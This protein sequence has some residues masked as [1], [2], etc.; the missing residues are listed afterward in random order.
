M[1]KKSL[2]KE[3]FLIRSNRIHGNRYDYSSV[4]FQ[5]TKTKVDIICYKHGIFSQQPA[6]HMNGQGCPFCYKDFIETRR[7]IKKTKKKQRVKVNPFEGKSL[8]EMKVIQDKKIKTN[9]KRYGVEN[10]SQIQSVKELK[11]RKLLTHEEICKEFNLLIKRYPKRYSHIISS[12]PS[13]IKILNEYPQTWSIAEKVYAFMYNDSKICLNGN[14]RRFIS[15]NKGFGYCG[16]GNNCKCYMN[17]I[18]KITSEGLKNRT[19][20]DRN[21]TLNKRISTTKE[22]YGV[23]N[24]SQN[25][26]IKEKKKTTSLKNNG[27]ISVLQS[28]T[29]KKGGMIRK[30]GVDNPMHLESV[31]EKVRKTNLKRYGTEVASKSDIIKNKTRQTMLERYGSQSYSQIHIPKQSMEILLDRNKLRNFISNRSVIEAASELG[32][33]QPCLSQYLIRNELNEPGRSSYERELLTMFQNWGL[34]VKKND[35]TEIYPNEIDFFFPQQRIGIEFCGLYYHSQIALEARNQSGRGYHLFKLNKCK[36]K[37][38]RLITIFED[39]WLNGKDIVI[40]RLKHLFGL[41]E[42]GASARQCSIRI[43]NEKESRN[44]LNRYHIQGNAN[45]SCIRYGAYHT[46]NLVGVM[47]FSKPRLA[48]GGNSSNDTYELLRFSTDGT[49]H[50]GL[51]SKMFKSLLREYKPKMVISYADRRW[52]TGEL[53][54]HL[55]FFLENINDPNYWYLDPRKTKRHHRFMFRKKVIVEK[56]GGDSN[57]SEWENMKK[58]NFDRIWDCG[59]LKFVWKES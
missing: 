3:E 49:I 33:S 57:L 50:S 47:T 30:Y 58:M 44:F 8:E 13:F 21:K 18:S 37:N 54:F 12:N 4:V 59:T 7:L 9:M 6:A 23:E 35:R 19:E 48:L 53:Y 22:R 11:K 45:G 15:I 20:E 41:S 51:A 27:F 24:I 55:G 38:I 10:V 39:E 52:S 2:T 25:D 46:N 16:I 43:I 5:N 32:I 42:R 28:S 26:F 36:E 29:L 56:M 17:D 14:E 31:R 40:R 34:D 1:A